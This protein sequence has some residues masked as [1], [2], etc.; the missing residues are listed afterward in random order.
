MTQPEVARE[1]VVEEVP[2][3]WHGD[4]LPP[5]ELP[6]VCTHRARSAAPW[7]D[8]QHTVYSGCVP[9]PPRPLAR[10]RGRPKGRDRLQ[11]SQAGCRQY[12][13]GRQ[14]GQHPQ[15]EHGARPDALP[16]RGACPSPRR[17]GE[18]RDCQPRRPLRSRLTAT[19]SRGAPGEA[20]GPPREVRRRRTRGSN[21]RVHPR[22]LIPGG[23]G[24]GRLPGPGPHC[25]APRGRPGDGPSGAGGSRGNPEPG[26]V[27]RRTAAA[28][29]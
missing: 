27:E 9:S 24:R 10:V 15:N 2:G 11:R 1:G 8:A 16:R 4:A 19:V 13:E 3:Q 7:L 28:T 23:A 12:H 18:G 26:P 6:L 21:E 25:P 22:D 17:A 29:D 5:R 20:G 14:S